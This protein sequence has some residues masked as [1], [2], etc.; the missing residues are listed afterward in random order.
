MILHQFAASSPLDVVRFILC[1]VCEQPYRTAVEVVGDAGDACA[2]AVRLGY[3]R[4]GQGTPRGNYY[5]VT[6]EGAAA[7]GLALPSDT[8]GY[9]QPLCERIRKFR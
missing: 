1:G 5:H 2:E 3:V 6:E 7:V 4:K 9:T 8:F